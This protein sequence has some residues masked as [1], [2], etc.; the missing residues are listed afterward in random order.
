MWILGNFA[1]TIGFSAV[2]AGLPSLSGGITFTF[3]DVS[4]ALSRIA[5]KIGAYWYVDYSATLHFWTGT[6]PGA[7]PA[8]L[9]PGGR[10][11]DFKISADL[12]Q[13]RT[14]ILVEGDGGT[15]ALGLPAGDTILPVSQTTPF[16]PA[17]GLATLGPW[18][19][20]YTGINA[21]GQKTNTTG[22]ISGGSGAGP[23][24]SPPAAPTAP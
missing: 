15:I 2:E 17:G 23:P 13:V 24:P 10:F 12:S 5:E 6:E 8:P 3:E 19:V 16:N 1:P 20:S 14:R 22:I 18:R 9:V 4:R 21:G 7:S 11:A